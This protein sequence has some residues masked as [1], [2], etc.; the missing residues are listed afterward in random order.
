[1][2]APPLEAGADQLT[3]ACPFPALAATLAGAPG[4][5]AGVTLVE[6]AEAG[7]VPT[8]LVAVTVKV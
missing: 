6:G 4:G 7:L 3:K 8:A 5:P 2:L 1:M